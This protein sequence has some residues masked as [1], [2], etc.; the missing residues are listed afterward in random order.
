MTGTPSATFHRRI[1][2]STPVN[3]ILK[4]SLIVYANCELG[5]LIGREDKD[6]YKVKNVDFNY[7][8]GLSETK[9]AKF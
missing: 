6:E 7:I 2:L 3:E 8:L 9:S 1:L 4:P 5:A